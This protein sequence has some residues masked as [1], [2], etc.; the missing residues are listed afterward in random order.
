MVYVYNF[1]TASRPA[2]QKTIKLTF[3]RRVIY[4]IL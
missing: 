2:M 1:F 3:S 4:T